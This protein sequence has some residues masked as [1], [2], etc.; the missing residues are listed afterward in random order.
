MKSVDK[1]CSRWAIFLSIIALVV[2]FTIGFIW[3]FSVKEQ[4]VVS[5][6]LI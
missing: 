3:I 4:S 1:K 5:G 2:S 6:G